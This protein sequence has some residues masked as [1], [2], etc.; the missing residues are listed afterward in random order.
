LLFPKEDTSIEE[1]SNNKGNEAERQR[2]EKLFEVIKKDKNNK[3]WWSIDQLEQFLFEL[4]QPVRIDMNNYHFY[5]FIN[6][7][8]IHIVL[9]LKQDL[10]TG[11]KGLKFVTLTKK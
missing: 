2:F 7:E 6:G 11:V 3:N 5:E 1:I 8:Q 10:E 4:P 9:A